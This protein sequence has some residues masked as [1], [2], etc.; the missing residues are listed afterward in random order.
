MQPKSEGS[1]L[2]VKLVR[3]KEKKM[4]GLTSFFLLVYVRGT[5]EKRE[6]TVKIN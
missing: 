1:I 5:L 3:L 2:S 6:K 4:Q